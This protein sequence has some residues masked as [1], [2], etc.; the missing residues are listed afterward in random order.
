[1][2]LGEKIS[3]IRKNKG[4]SQEALAEKSNVSLRTIQRIESGNTTPRPYTLSVIAAALDVPIE[5]LGTSGTEHTREVLP[6]LRM[7]NLAALSVIVLPVVHLLIIAFTWRRFNALL[8]NDFTAKKIISFQILW[9][10]ATVVLVIVLPLIQRATIQSFVIGHLPPTFFIV[11]GI[12]LLVN[13]GLTIRTALQL[14]QDQIR[15]YS[16]IPVLF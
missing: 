3:A 8:M 6:A 14:Q 10:L 1:M 7:I 2:E 11:Y 15:V 9:T 12:M 13:I 5:E 4:M 16:F